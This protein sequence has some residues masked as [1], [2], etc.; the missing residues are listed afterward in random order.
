LLGVF[1]I[2]W[3]F[4]AIFLLFSGIYGFCSYGPWNRHFGANFWFFSRFYGMF[5]LPKNMVCY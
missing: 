3:I 5:I 1:L 4:M 2:L